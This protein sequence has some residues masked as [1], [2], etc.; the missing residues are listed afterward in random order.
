MLALVDQ[1]IAQGSVPDEAIILAALLWPALEARAAQEEFAPGRVGR[2]QWALFV[3]RMLP[4][5]GQPVAFAKRVVERACQAGGLMAFVRMPDATARLPKKI[6]QKG[7]FIDACRLARLLGYDL[8]TLAGGRAPTEAPEPR[9]PR[10]RRRRR[11]PPQAP[12]EA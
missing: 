4:E 1:E 11:R 8:E 12:A 5:L 9:R 10:R 6:A 2:V 7:Y 3:R